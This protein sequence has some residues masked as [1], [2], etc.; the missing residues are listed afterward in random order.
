VTDSGVSPLAFPGNPD[1]V[2]KATSYEHDEYGIT[3][4]EPDGIARMHEKRLAKQDRLAREVDNLEAVKVYGDSGASTAL[5]TWGSTK[6]AC[7]E[8]GEDMGL[9][10]IQPVILEPFPIK[11]VR[12]ALQ[13]VKHLIGVELNATGSLSRLLAR[14]GIAVGDLI[15]K[16][17]GRPYSVDGLRK[18]IEGVTG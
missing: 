5:I 17:D 18:Q 9:K 14:Y 6:G 13:G 10:V 4:E 7:V 12:E 15:L 11:A 2:V 1:A 3:T 8:V 16:Y